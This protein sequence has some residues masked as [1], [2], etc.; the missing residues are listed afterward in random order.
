MNAFTIGIPSF[1]LALE[2]NKDRIKGI[3][4]VNILKNSIPAGLTTVINIIMCIIVMQVFGL[5]VWQYSTLCVCM[6]SA[7]A[8]MILFQVSVPFNT[9]RKILFVLMVGGMAVGITC[10]R[11]FYGINV[12]NFSVM[13]WKMLLLVVGMTC[14]SLV[15]FNLLT[16]PMKRWAR[17]VNRKFKGKSFR[18]KNS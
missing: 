14:V 10:F 4:I 5:D 15:I 1:I 17:R 12:F 18:P 2:P 7:A 16:R 3:F 11:D 8:F 9:V 13:N 6:T